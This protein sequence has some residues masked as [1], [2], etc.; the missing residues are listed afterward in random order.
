[1]SD[2]AP[3]GGRAFTK[4]ELLGYLAEVDAELPPGEDVKIAVVGGAAVM[5]LASASA[6]SAPSPQYL[7]A[8]KLLAGR[9]IDVEDAVPLAAAAGITTSDE[10]L[11]LVQEA[12][13]KAWQTPALQYRTETVAGAVADLL[14]S[15]A[16]LPDSGVD[17]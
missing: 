12:F 7:L 6:C 14:Q 5:F 16:D 17:V 10:M 4:N 3:A 11:D 1:M 15:G 8:T 9:P 2:A 13:P